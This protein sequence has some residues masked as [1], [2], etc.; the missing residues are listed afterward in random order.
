MVNGGLVL[1]GYS[2]H[3]I[4][5]DVQMVQASANLLTEAL[6]GTIELS[7]H[8]SMEVALYVGTLT[9]PTITARAILAL[10]IARRC[11]L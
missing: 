10:Q 7:H 5:Q 9:V 6:L 2:Q 8:K 3:R 1:R 4:R 11:T